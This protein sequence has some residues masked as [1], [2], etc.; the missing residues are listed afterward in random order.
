MHLAKHIPSRDGLIAD[1]LAGLTGAVAGAP[2]AMAFAVIAGVSPVYGLYTAIISTIIGALVGSS[3][4]MTV[5]PTNALALIVGTTLVRFD[6]GKG[7]ERMIVL[8][9]L[10]GIF[11]T[12]F[13]LLRM[14]NITRFVSNAVMT[15]FITGAMVLIILA[16]LRPFTGYIST[17]DGGILAQT[18]D[19]L[20]HLD[21]GDWRSFSMGLLAAAIIVMLHQYKRTRGVATLTAII[22]TGIIVALL[23][24]QS[25]EIVRDISAIPRG[26]PAFNAPDPQY[27][28]ALWQVAL[29]MAV[30]GL[31]QGAGISQ[32]IPQPDGTQPDVTRDFVG[33]G[34]ANLV[35]AFFQG[36]PTSGS[37]SRTAVNLSAGAHSRLA[38]VLAGVFVAFI[39]LIFGPMIERVALAA[40]AAHLIVAA[41]SLI[42]PG[43]LRQVWEVDLPAKVA[44]LTTF[45]STLVMPLEYSIYIGVLLSLLLY[46]YTSAGNITA[47]RL[48][49][50]QN[51][52]YEEVPLPAVLPSHEPIIVTVYGNL[53]FAAVGAL[54]HLLPLPGDSELPIVILR[55]KGNHYLGST[56]I[57]LL[58]RYAAQLEARGGVLILCGLGEVIIGQLQRTGALD[59]LGKENVFGEQKVLLASTS[60]ALQ[61]ARDWLAEQEAH[62]DELV[63]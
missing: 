13:G 58:E 63:V 28:P 46:V 27:I 8:T 52:H 35:T 43:R 26:L 45:I 60:A 2:Q 11:Q 21:Q 24:W 3:V 39:L 16:Q 59:R 9:L 53:Y 40:L 29:A 31:V 51:G 30:L 54:E 62:F 5:G 17:S 33:Q 18:W 37:L 10:V 15:G 4:Y 14:G 38:N 48:V 55:L 12:G 61:R 25:V 22:V 50:A 6:D 23:D 42:S 20:R 49:P 7:L 32:N 36:M 56:G 19:W 47:M 41:S 44:L 57:R 34:A 1:L